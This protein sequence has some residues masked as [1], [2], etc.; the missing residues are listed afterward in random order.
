MRQPL[1]WIEWNLFV[2]VHECSDVGKW[3]TFAANGTQCCSSFYLRIR[4]LYERMY[5]DL[6]DSAHPSARYRSRWFG[7]NGHF[8]TKCKWPD[9]SHLLKHLL[10]RKKLNIGFNY[11]TLHEHTGWPKSKSVISNGS[12]SET[13]HFWTHVCK[14]KIGLRGG[15]FFWQKLNFWNK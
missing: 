5:C 12:E 3:I 9:S 11:A 10:S 15:S 4:L 2:V 7:V 1:S 8:F 13:E 14:V 6:L